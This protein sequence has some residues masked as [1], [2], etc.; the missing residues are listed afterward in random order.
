MVPVSGDDR[1]IRD[2]GEGN[3]VISL[4]TKLQKDLEESEVH[5]VGRRERERATTYVT[6]CVTP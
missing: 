1:K 2:W 3:N 6:D 5:G 4:A